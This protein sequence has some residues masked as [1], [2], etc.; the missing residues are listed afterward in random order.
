MDWGIGGIKVSPNPPIRG[1]GGWGDEG[2]VGSVDR[3]TRGSRA[4]D[5]NHE[6]L[7]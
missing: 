4:D 3:G 1:S 2:I 5:D 6:D 7:H